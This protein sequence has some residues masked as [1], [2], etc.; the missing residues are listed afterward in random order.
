MLADGESTRSF[1][2][3]L[4]AAIE[5]GAA[6]PVLVVGV[7]NSGD[8]ADRSDMRSQE[9][10]PGYKPRRFAAHL[11][12]VTGGVIPWAAERFPVADG[13]WISAGCSSGAAWA[14]AAAQRRPEVFGGVAG[15]SAG[16]VPRRVA[17]ASRGVRHYL[18]AGTLE[19]SFRRQTREWAER[20]RRAGVP[21]QHREWVGGHDPFWWEHSLPEALAWLLA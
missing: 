5:S 10:L 8:A 19:E 20:L 2:Q 18:G 17:G 4:E 6:P 9:Y 16:I 15:L 12:F 7:H 13:P 11:S 14:I 21:C 1:A 3:V